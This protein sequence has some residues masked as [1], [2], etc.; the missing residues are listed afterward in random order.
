V[1]ITATQALGAQ[2]AL[3][4]SLPTCLRAAPE[5]RVNEM[6]E[7]QA[8]SIAVAEHVATI[9]LTRPEV[10]NR[11]DAALHQEFELALRQVENDESARVAV[12]CAVGKYFS[13]GGDTALMEEAFASIGRRTSLVDE[14]RRL[15]QALVSFPKPLIVALE[16]DSHGVGST[17][18]MAADAI[19]AH[20]DV[21][22]A[23][24]HVRSGVAA[25]DGGA[26]VW[27]MNMPAA[28][29]KRH[30]LTGDPITGEVAYRLGL[31][32]DLAESID[33]VRPVAFALA[34]RM[35][36]LPPLAVQMTKRIFNATMAHRTSEGLDVGFYLEAITLSTNDLQE[37]IASFKERRPGEW[38]GT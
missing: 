36:A 26:V 7:Y 22:I 2:S 28:L 13:G 5:K 18:V 14:G 33:D 1:S 23:D 10:S 20:R 19:V 31:I 15:F 35:A 38:T 3:E 25:G 21:R 12:V 37:A 16:G 27:P 8:L 6:P 9:E 30:L 17:I 11:F 34:A 4:V 24:A 29:A 32:T